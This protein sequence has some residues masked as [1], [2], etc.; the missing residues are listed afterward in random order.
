MTFS[1]YKRGLA[2][3]QLINHTKSHTIM[4]GEKGNNFYFHGKKI[5]NAKFYLL[6]SHIFLFVTGIPQPLPP[7]Q[8]IYYTWI[9]PESDRILH[10]S[11]VGTKKKHEF[12]NSLQSDGG[13]FI[14]LGPDQILTWVSF[15]DGMQRILFFNAPRF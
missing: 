9:V 2:P 5:V 13:D 14:Q 12:E 7:G 15:L 6:Y 10:W 3:V 1:A 11:F 4:Y 8:S